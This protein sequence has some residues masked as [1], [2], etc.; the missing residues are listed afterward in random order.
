MCSDQTSLLKIICVQAASINKPHLVF[1]VSLGSEVIM[2]SVSSRWK[3]R[4]QNIFLFIC[5]MPRKLHFVRSGL[6]PEVQVHNKVTAFLSYMTVSAVPP[7]PPVC[8][9]TG[10]PMVKGNVTLSCKSSHGKPVP[11]Y[12]WTKAAP[13]SEVFFSP[14]QSECL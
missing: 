14:M 4:G 13:V 7:S 3:Q 12:K 1:R 8:S 9:M 5:G 11:Q 6:K 2:S 10:N